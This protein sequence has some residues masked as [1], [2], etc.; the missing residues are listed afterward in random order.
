MIIA[1]PQALW[2]QAHSAASLGL[3][4]DWLSSFLSVIKSMFGH[5]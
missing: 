5:L 3:V 1:S 4:E 2:D